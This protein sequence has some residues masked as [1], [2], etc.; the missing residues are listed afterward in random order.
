MTQVIAPTDKET[1]IGL[2]ESPAARRRSFQRGVSLATW[3]RLS[4]DRMAI[5]STHGNRTFAELDA[6]CNRLARALAER[7]V[8]PDDGLALF[9]ANRPEFVEVM[10][11][12]E[13][14][15]IRVTPIRPDLTPREVEYI[16]DDSRATAIITDMSV[17]SRLIELFRQKTE[18]RTKLS[19]GADTPGMESYQAALAAADSR[20]FETDRIGIP[21]IY[22][23]GTTGSPKGVY[24]SEPV[25]RPAMATIGERLKL[26]SNRD[27][28]LAPLALCRPGVFNLSTRLPLVCGVRVFLVEEYEPQAI[29]ELIT[30]HHITYAYLTPFLLHRLSQLPKS[31]R[32]KH[33][34]GSLR[35]VL[36]TGAPCAVTLKRQM[37]EWFGPVVTEC[38]AGTEG[39]DIVIS[40]DEWLKKPGSVG[41][42]DDRVAI[43]DERDHVLPANNIGQIF[44]VAPQRGR[45]EYFN[46]PEKTRSAYRGDLYT[47]GDHGYLDEDGYL[48]ITGRISEI[49]NSGGLKIYPAEIDAILLDH[50]AVEDA[51][52]IGVP[53]PEMGEEVKALIKLRPGQDAHADLLAEL[54]AL[55]RDNLAPYKC[56]GS[57]ERIDEVPRLSTGK[58][59]RDQLRQ[60]YR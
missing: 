44:L 33:H 24:R 43:L 32:E 1:K 29:L 5:E 26:A 59:L 47:M 9:C 23:S 57:F 15:G 19:I 55:C 30:R 41:K 56:P 25:S 28:A 54:A 12:A 50:P 46:D 14:A 35:N 2:D 18:I 8:G 48:Y 27:V 7:G 16:L 22:T 4:P 6:N 58:V 31:I 40:S 21:M 38:Y 51:A 45:F 42:A 37:I 36:H 49:I 60:R 13:R 34:L 53:N 39:G 20:P 11:A 17:G 10:F 3:A 52:C